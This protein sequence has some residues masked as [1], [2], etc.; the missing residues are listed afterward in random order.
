MDAKYKQFDTTYTSPLGTY[1][2]CWIRLESTA[3]QDLFLEKLASL[4]DSSLARLDISG[5]RLGECPP[6]F[7]AK[8]F[9]SLQKTP[10]NFHTLDLS[11]NQLGL[12]PVHDLCHLLS[13]I[14]S[15]VVDVN[16]THNKLK[17]FSEKELDK[18]ACAFPETVKVVDF[19]SNS[20][21]DDCVDKLA[22]IISDHSVCNRNN[23]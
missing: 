3:Q 4:S 7:H 20:L 19:A 1:E 16:F 15:S 9:E 21:S 12:V 13:H 22:G 23:P 17:N 5:N 8:V 6:A 11:F 10:A 14:P 18:I 2:L